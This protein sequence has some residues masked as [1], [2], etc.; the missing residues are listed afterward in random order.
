MPPD[1]RVRRR[2]VQRT[3]K[4][5]GAACTYG[6]TCN[7]GGGVCSKGVCVARGKSGEACSFDTCATGLRCRNTCEP[8]VPA[9]K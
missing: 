5:L 9:C 8:A 7:G 2:E 1:A 4:A 3:N 6:D